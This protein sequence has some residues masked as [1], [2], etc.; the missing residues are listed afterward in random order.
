LSPTLRDCA[1]DVTRYKHTK[2]QGQEEKRLKSELIPVDY[3][4]S[5]TRNLG[6]KNP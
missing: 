6:E 3:R 1:L 2:Y 4:L 5:G